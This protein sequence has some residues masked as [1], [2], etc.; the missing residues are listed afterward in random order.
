MKILAPSIIDPAIFKGGASTAS[1]GL[2]SLLSESPLGAEITLLPSR[3]TERAWRHRWRRFSS[4]VEAQFSA[5]PSKA[6]FH[7]TPSLAARFRREFETGKYDLVLIN[8]SDLMWIQDLV[9]DRLPT[10]VVAH[11]LEH[12]LFQRQL[13]TIGMSG[14]LKW[15]FRG[16]LQKLEDMELKGFQRASGVIFLSSSEQQRMG[17]RLAPLN[18]ICIPPVFSSTVAP[19]DRTPGEVLELGFLA[20]L[21][22]WPNA[23]CLDWFLDNV[24]PRCSSQ[25]RLQVF[26]VGSDRLAAR[27]GVDLVGH[28]YVP[29]IQTVW[30]ACDVMVSPVLQ[31]GG[32]NIKLAE[33]IYNGIPVVASPFS[34][35][36]LPV[37]E[38]PG[39]KVVETADDWV[40]CLDSPELREFIR[41]GV[42]ESAR[43]VFC[44]EA[45]RERL[46][47]FVK[48]IG[49]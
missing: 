33:A 3:V 17:Q 1:S 40:A 20:N 16:D 15:A 14:A 46:Q 41:H 28:G 47:A 34:I 7:R 30:D 48:A 4:V 36:G 23:H 45:Q 9:D 13:D 8:G 31:G 12:E 26:G 22:W 25:V 19:R 35:D 6:L 49:G 24:L 39:L 44:A 11:N 18:S 42:P 5:L 37:R 27:P 32:V 10:V 38:G 21:D 29:D 43:S 2:L